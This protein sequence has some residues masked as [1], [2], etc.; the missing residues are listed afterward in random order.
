MRGK[1]GGV[2]RAG[3]GRAETNQAD[4][5]R[6]V[7]RR[8][9]PGRAE[10]SRAGP[11]VRAEPSPSRAE[12]GPSPSPSR[13]EPGRRGA[14][15]SPGVTGGRPIARSRKTHCTTKSA[16]R[17]RETHF[18]SGLQFLSRGQCVKYSISPRNCTLQRASRLRN[19]FPTN[20]TC[21]RTSRLHQMHIWKNKCRLVYTKCYFF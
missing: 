18:C 16:S 14:A 2:V 19:S 21:Q 12:P 6:A 1:F 11:S 5:S 8:A 13:A 7:P 15:D 10:L 3:T 17:A 4:L 9:G 20:C